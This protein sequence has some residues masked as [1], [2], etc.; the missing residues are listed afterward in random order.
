MSRLGSRVKRLLFP[1]RCSACGALLDWYAA[2]ENDPIVIAQSSFGFALRKDASCA[3][4]FNASGKTLTIKGEGVK[5]VLNGNEYTPDAE[6]KIVITLTVG[7]VVKLENTS[8]KTAELTFAV[9]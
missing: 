1:P 8:D 5:A 3:F 6:N 4:A 9:E 7:A 2:D